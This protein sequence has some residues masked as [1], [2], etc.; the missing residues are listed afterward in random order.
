MESEGKLST[1]VMVSEE[2]MNLINDYQIGSNQVRITRYY[3][4]IT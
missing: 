3:P 4:P 1:E 2:D